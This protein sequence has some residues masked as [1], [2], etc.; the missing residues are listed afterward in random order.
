MKEA[1]ALAGKTADTMGKL[2]T[3]GI[4]K[5]KEFASR[6]PSVDLKVGK[7]ETSAKPS[8]PAA[9]PIVKATPNVAVKPAAK[10]SASAPKPKAKPT[11]KPVAEEVGNT[12]TK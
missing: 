10:T 8:E 5:A 4:A 7:N 6:V 3:A 2:A 9:K 1:K 11:A 12:E